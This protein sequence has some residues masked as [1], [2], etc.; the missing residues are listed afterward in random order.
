MT[1]NS[2]LARMTMF[3]LPLARPLLAE[4]IEASKREALGTYTEDYVR[5]AGYRLGPQGEWTADL[6]P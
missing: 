3:Y 2:P 1:P 6:A 4:L 5:G